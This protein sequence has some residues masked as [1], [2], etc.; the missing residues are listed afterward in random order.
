MA[1]GPA[2]GMAWGLLKDK[3]VDLETKLRFT[4]SLGFVVSVFVAI[5]FVAS[6][7]AETFF[8]DAIG[9]YAG[10]LAAGLLVL[11]IA[12]LERL[13]SKLA[14][15]V[16][17]EPVDEEGYETFRKLE[18]YRATYEEA[19]ADAALSDRERRTLDSMAGNLGLSKE[20]RGFVEER[21]AQ[22]RDRARS[23]PSGSVVEAGAG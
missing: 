19:T 5:F 4:V 9:P 13:G 20:E 8:T 22:E 23:D 3:V 2:A 18:V 7:A 15:G 12:P 17:E 6:E 11:A 21:V 10:L 1:L 16:V 14:S